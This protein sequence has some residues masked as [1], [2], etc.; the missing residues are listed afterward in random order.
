M[1]VEHRPG[2]ATTLSNAVGFRQKYVAQ[3]AL[4]HIYTYEGVAYVHAEFAAVLSSVFFE[5]GDE[6][7]PGHLLQSLDLNVQR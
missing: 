3:A 7:R 2:S 6:L 5:P 1:T 4:Y